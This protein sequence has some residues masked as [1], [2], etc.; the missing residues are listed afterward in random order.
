MSIQTIVFA[1]QMKSDI[2]MIKIITILVLTAYTS[3]VVA[4]IS[5]I[6]L[7][8][9][10]V[11]KNSTLTVNWISDNVETS[12]F[13]YLLLVNT[14][15]QSVTAIDSGLNISKLS[16]SFD[17]TKEAGTYFLVI[18]DGLGGEYYS[19][20]FVVA[21]ETGTTD[22]EEEE[23]GGG[24]GRSVGQSVRQALKIS[25]IESVEKVSDRVSRSIGESVGKS[26][27]ETLG[28]SVDESVKTKMSERSE[29]LYE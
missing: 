12:N 18:G 8:S 7:S 20:D 4:V 25:F 11:P 1:D 13:G 17:V 22:T 21:D 5:N 24:V 26:V 29:E 10:Q 23:D 6:T 16:E 28:R 27:G 15:D 2:N 14:Q 19:V 9:D 3:M